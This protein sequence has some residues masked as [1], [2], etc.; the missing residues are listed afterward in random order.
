M[1]RY[2]VGGL[3]AIAILS[4]TGTLIGF[5]GATVAQQ[6]QPDTVDLAAGEQFYSEN[7]ASCH[8]VNLEG[9]DD[10]QSPDSDGVL[11][12]SPHDE[13]GHTWHHGDALLF[14]YTKLGGEAALAEQ[15]VEFN[16]GMPGFGAALS[17][18]EIW[19]ILAYIK[20]TW[21]DRVQEVQAVRTE[22]EE[23][24]AR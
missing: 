13:T 22:A 20:S 21:P 8:G 6:S 24:W 23:L 9:Q 19:D 5:F 2:V 15:G 12:A 14:T 1:K 11:P 4:A 10:W 17:D 7:C 16:S 18:Q 3:I